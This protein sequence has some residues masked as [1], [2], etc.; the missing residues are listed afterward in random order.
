MTRT[1]IHGRSRFGTRS[2]WNHLFASIQRSGRRILWASSRDCPFPS[3]KNIFTLL[4]P[5]YF[6]VEEVDGGKQIVVGE[7]DRGKESAAR[8]IKRKVALYSTFPAIPLACAEYFSN[9]MF[10][11]QISV[12]DAKNRQPI[13]RLRALLDAIEAFEHPRAFA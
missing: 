8:F 12:I 7:H 4:Q 1:R 6:L 10:V 3:K 11:V 13:A 9:E 5:A 2:K